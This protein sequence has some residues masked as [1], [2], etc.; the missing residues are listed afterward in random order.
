MCH[1]KEKYCF[2]FYGPRF[3]VHR[4]CRVKP[5]KFP[6]RGF[7]PGI[8]GENGNLTLLVSGAAGG[9]AGSG[10]LL[11]F[12]RSAAGSGSFSGL[13]GSAAGRTAG[14][15]RSGFHFLVPAKQ[16]RKCHVCSLQV[17]NSAGWVPSVIPIVRKRTSC[18]K[19]ALFYN[20][21]TFL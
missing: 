18:N 19:Y 7:S 5:Q 9:T 17:V 13:V 2:I 14:R 4:S 15:S 21:A 10:F 11:R 3:I 1:W 12:V 20:P 8:A 6:A 16:V